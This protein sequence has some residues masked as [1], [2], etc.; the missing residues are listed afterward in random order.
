MA[1][2]GGIA[3]A[4]VLKW[5]GLGFLGVM[6][7]NALSNVIG[8][9]TGQNPMAQATSTMVQTLVPMIVT[10]MPVMMVMNMMMSMMNAIMTPFAALTRPMVPTAT[11]GL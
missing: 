1:A 9:I 11:F 5:F 2:A 6:G 10:L 3:L 7:L 8:S 4:E